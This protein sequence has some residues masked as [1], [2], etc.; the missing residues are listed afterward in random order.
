MTAAHYIIHRVNLEIEAPDEQD[1]GRLQDEAAYIFYNRIL[2][3]LE[4]LLDRLVPDETVVCIDTL[5]L[6]LDPLD[7]DTFS[8]EFGSSVLSALQKRFEHVAD[9]ALGRVAQGP[10]EHLIVRTPVQRTFDTLLHF[11]ATGQLPWWSE[12]AFDFWDKDTLDIL[13]LHVQQ[14][15]PA[16]A[17]SLLVLL[18]TDTSA[19]KRLLLQFP[20]AFVNRLIRLLAETGTTGQKKHADQLIETLLRS[21]AANPAKLTPPA[22]SAELNTLHS[23][24][25]WLLFAQDK[26]LPAPAQVPAQVQ[27]LLSSSADS[28]EDMN[29]Q[30]GKGTFTRSP[31]RGTSESSRTLVE[32]KAQTGTSKGKLHTET[33]R[34]K[35]LP[36]RDVHNT[37]IVAGDQQLLK[38]DAGSEQLP[39]QP[40]TAAENGIYVDHAGLVLLH[41]FFEYFFREFDL[42]DGPHFC[43]TAA[44]ALAVHLLQYLVTGRESPAEHVLTLEKFLCGLQPSDGVPR[45]IQLTARMQEEADTLL[46][47]AIGHWKILKSTSPAGLREGFLQRPG[48]L[49]VN[50]FENRLTV[51]AHSH[52][53]LLNYLPWGLG[54][55][56]LPWLTAPLLVDWHS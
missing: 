20:L 35:E 41:P 3:G 5:N 25:R 50:T 36:V 23:L 42:L 13:L 47:A 22:V 31:H 16:A 55:I 46:R 49:T 19:T 4:Q 15:G 28:F 27:S 11:L 43:D 10:D 17:S 34:K 30:K 12:R 53:I 9:T 52:D 38:E 1:A 56:R 2:P 29:N 51:E 48:T 44:R 21:W 33:T 18:A 14:T 24:L 7:A 8:E 6:V 32:E 45:F 26:D 40:R 39:P 54:I 37:A